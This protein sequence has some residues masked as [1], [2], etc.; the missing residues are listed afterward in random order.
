ML[1]RSI[2]LTCR[3]FFFYYSLARLVDISAINLI[4]N[5]IKLTLIRFKKWSLFCTFPWKS[6][7]GFSPTSHNLFK[8]FF[9]LLFYVYGHLIF[10]INT[11][12]LRIWISPNPDQNNNNTNSTGSFTYFYGIYVKLRTLGI[13]LMHPWPL[14]SL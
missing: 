9:Q 5:L 13:L 14:R 7:D 3:N 6:L 2:E 10:L 8:Y 1:W 11:Q 4:G 12:H